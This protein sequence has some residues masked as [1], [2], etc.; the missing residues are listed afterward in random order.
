MTRMKKPLG[1]KYGKSLTEIVGTSALEKALLYAETP[2]PRLTAEQQ[3]ELVGGS[4]RSRAESDN[5]PT[6]RAHGRVR[7]R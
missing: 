2:R 1:E 6:T 4:R 3:R 5:Y 7:A